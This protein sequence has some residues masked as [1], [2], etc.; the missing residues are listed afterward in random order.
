[1]LER[2][3]LVTQREKAADQRDAIAGVRDQ[4]AEQRDLAADDHDVTRST[5]ETLAAGVEAANEEGFSRRAL[6]ALTTGRRE[7][8]VDRNRAAGDRRFA[9]G[10][11]S[12]AG[13]DRIAA[14]LDRELASDQR[15]SAHID[16]LTGTLRRGAGFF[17]LDRE[18]ARSRRTEQGLVLGFADVVGLKT[19]NDSL[20][21]A[22]GDQ[23]LRDVADA[24][25]NHLRPYDP[26][27]RYGGDEFV[28]TFSEL[29]LGAAKDRAKEINAWLGSRG[30]SL[31]IGLAELR[32]GDS[33]GTL[34][35]RADWDL[36][37]QRGGRRAAPTGT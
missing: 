29:T 14:A 27:V 1:M 26:I 36:Y 33:L 20:G 9:A 5:T 32:E 3:R 22:R 10:D 37:E 19:V 35:N 24:L 7:A 4:A 16:E 2:E 23:M 12:H 30:A 17:E 11:R 25:R 8:G 6:D 31:T 13:A 15:A 34:V 18:I 21:H 28:F